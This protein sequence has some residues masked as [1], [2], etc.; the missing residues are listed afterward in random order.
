MLGTGLGHFIPL[1]A[2]LGF[3]IMCL[4]SLGGRPLLGLYYMIPFLPY[5]TLRDRFVDYPLGGNM[6]T[7]LVIS[8]IV[9]CLIRG[10]HLPKSRLYAIWLVFGVYLYLSMWM[11]TALGNAPA[12]LWL[13]DANF[14]AW[15]DYMLI[16]LIFVASSLAIEDRKAI[17]MVILIT[18]ISLL[19][20]DRTC[21]L[22]SMSRTWT[23]FDETKRDGGPLAYG[24]NQ[25]A[26]FLAQFGMFY[27]GFV[28]FVKRKK[29]KIFG[30]GLVA[31]TLFATMYT[32]SRGGYIAVLFSILVLGL[33]Q[34]RK[35]LLFLGVFLFTWQTVVPTA[36]RERVSMTQTSD[37]QLEASA[38]SRVD[39]WEYAE[40]SI[41]NSPIVGS[42]FATFQF[43][44][45]V[46]NL[47]D[48]HN[49]YVK[50][51]VETGIIGLVMAFLLL[52]QSLATS[53]R[54]FKRSIDP[55]YKGLGL[56]LLLAFCSCIV[57]NFFGDRWTYLEITGLLWV[58][59]GAAVRATHLMES[60]SITEP[61]EVDSS[62][63]VNP[64]M[65]Y[66]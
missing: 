43:G 37:G 19:L 58:L 31:M 56:G 38:Q 46:A 33:L 6:L 60:Q 40:K 9:G 35:L 17:R 27:W 23:N 5:R 55:L 52:Q 59:M 66:P 65:A 62:V 14:S 1:V 22:E 45:H 54:L 63:S 51:M 29:I 20:I 8:V 36:V 47:K 64:Y 53:Y 10:K 16:P 2:Y 34:N 24:S 44:E 39:L 3:C 21:I 15:K 49:W 50:V 61:I 41:L 4:A 48:T 30:Y 7:I 28:R 26:A 32:F 12:P 25:T 11:G 18:A 57:A 42:G 13:S